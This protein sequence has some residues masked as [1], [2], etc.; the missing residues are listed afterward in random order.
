MAMWFLTPVTALLSKIYDRL[1]EN[2]KETN[3]RLDKIADL[4]TPKAVTEFKMKVDKP[5]KQ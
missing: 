1:G 4:L 2:Q 3:A 5:T